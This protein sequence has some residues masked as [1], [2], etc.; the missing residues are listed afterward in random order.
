MTK[1]YEADSIVDE[2]RRD[3]ERQTQSPYT[4]DEFIAIESDRWRKLNPYQSDDV[5]MPMEAVMAA[6]AAERAGITWRQEAAPAPDDENAIRRDITG[7]MISALSD[8]NA[9]GI[10]WHQEPEPTRPLFNRITL[11]DKMRAYFDLGKSTEGGRLDD[12]AK[13]IEDMRSLLGSRILSLE[14]HEDWAKSQIKNLTLLAADAREAIG[15]L[16]ARL[17]AAETKI[18]QLDNSQLA[19]V[20]YEERLDEWRGQIDERV[21]SLEKDLCALSIAT[22]RSDDDLA[23]RISMLERQ[24]ARPIVAEIR[25]PT[26]ARTVYNALEE[27]TKDEIR[28]LIRET[29]Y[30][31]PL[32]TSVSR[33]LLQ[34]VRAL[35][36]QIDP[37]PLIAEH[38]RRLSLQ[39]ERITE[40]TNRIARVD[41][42]VAVD[43]AD[44]RREVRRLDTDMALVRDAVCPPQCAAPSI[45]EPAMTS[46]DDSR[47]AERIRAVQFDWYR[48]VT[49][50]EFRT[51]VGVVESPDVATGVE[52][53]ASMCE[54]RGTHPPVDWPAPTPTML[55]SPVFEVIW[56]AIKTWDIAVPGAYSGYCEANG[57]HVR[58]ILDAIDGRTGGESS[59]V[60]VLG[61]LSAHL[62]QVRYALRLACLQL[63]AD[64]AWSDDTNLADVVSKV[65][66]SHVLSRLSVVAV[67]IQP[68]F[69]FDDWWVH[70]TRDGVYL[71]NGINVD[72]S[73]V[74][75][76]ALY[77]Y[78]RQTWNAAQG[79]ASIRDSAPADA[80]DTP[81]AV[82]AP[83]NKTTTTTVI[84]D[85]LVLD[86]D[87]PIV[88]KQTAESPV[89]KAVWSVIEGWF[90]RQGEPVTGREVLSILR[91]IRDAGIATSGARHDDLAYALGR[92]Y[93][94]LKDLEPYEPKVADEEM[95]AIRQVLGNNYR[96]WLRPR[97]AG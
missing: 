62:R 84:D 42:S 1:D 43:I 70:F 79:R 67:P 34:R 44:L 22:R 95:E 55:E 96:D 86:F 26:G 2:T 61:R 78:L 14:Y 77:R 27:R 90:E 9:A 51:S 3:V 18:G 38:D 69:T 46:V 53:G 32:S 60:T 39:L 92:A 73:S 66:M 21:T 13:R 7:G 63:G 41:D 37:C 68:D 89:F 81:G 12:L 87:G 28:T 65:L 80:P 64:T 23:D 8:T 19:E 49:G 56:Q 33:N 50:Q 24:V 58:A 91:A 74:T 36:E 10:T 97:E 15:E 30:G 5:D 4:R 94:A 20:D 45:E 17:T 85:T 29:V 82:D 25:D 72:R 71:G 47:C 76:N 59:L 75:G 88:P 31:E 40:L 57:N 16:G 35:E 93:V 52:F 6:A 11:E 83:A 54:R 48:Q